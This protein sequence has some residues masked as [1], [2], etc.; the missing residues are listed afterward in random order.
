[1]IS[2]HVCAC[3]FIQSN[4]YFS[5][6]QWISLPLSVEISFQIIRQLKHNEFT[7]CF[8]T[9]HWRFQKSQHLILNR[10]RFLIIKYL[11]SFL[12][13]ERILRT[14]RYLDYLLLSSSLRNVSERQSKE[15]TKIN[16][17][18]TEINYFASLL[19]IISD[20]C[21]LKDTNLYFN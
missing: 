5:W 16:A 2:V 4:E 8:F 14:F 1:M 13:L 15:K 19:N 3:F 12:F 9:Y 17:Q 10:K 18:C 11:Y 20:V 7:Y 21:I 6:Y